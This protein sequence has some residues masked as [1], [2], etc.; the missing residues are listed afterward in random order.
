VTSRRAVLAGA[1]ALAGVGCR[2]CAVAPAALRRGVAWLAAQ[3][4]PRG[5]F[6]SQTYGFF[7]GGASLTPLVTLALVE[8]GLAPEAVERARR[9]MAR[10]V[11]GTGALGRGTPDYPTY[12]ASLMARAMG[13]HAWDPSETLGFLRSQQYRPSEGWPADHPA[14]GG[15]GFGTPLPAP[16][17]AGHVD[18]SMTRRAI[19]ALVALGVGRSD[20]SRA[21]ARRF[22]ERCRAPGGGLIYSPSEPALNKG[23][24][25]AGYGSATCDGVLALAALGAGP[26]ELAPHLA[27]LA[28]HH[29]ADRT[30]GVA[31]AGFAEAMRGYYQCAAAEVFA[32]FGGPAGWAAG[33]RADLAARQRDDGSWRNPQPHQKEDDPLVATAFAVRCLARCGSG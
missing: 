25:G 15:F 8:T 18:L 29:R 28:A 7:A 23:V 6:P 24:D 1:L 3:Q 12:A 30:P 22:V 33:L 26:D 10:E 27:W 4:S 17:R 5:H 14:V 31:D 20:P 11:E 16:P 19:E 32:R 9:W 21:L 13:A 2:G